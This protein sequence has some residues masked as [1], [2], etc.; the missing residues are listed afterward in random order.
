M[1]KI[2]SKELRFKDENGGEFGDWEEKKLGDFTSVNQGLQIAISSRFFENGANRYFYITNEVLRKDSTTKYYIEN[3]PKSVLCTT[4]DI[5]MTRTGNTGN[6]V[7]NIAGAFHNNFFKIGFNRKHYYKDYMY[8]ILASK[9]MKKLMLKLAG[10]STIPDLNHRDFYS[11]KI[12]M[13]SFPEQQKI[14]DFLS[15]LDEKIDVEKQILDK[16]KLAKKG[17][18]QQMFC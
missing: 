14:A 12:A 8:Q 15:T 16:L 17:L 11:I 5:L 7:T 9:H 4:D 1:Q 18:L 3:P 10:N 6:V 13:P 2:F